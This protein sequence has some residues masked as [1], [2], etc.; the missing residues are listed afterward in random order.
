MIGIFSRGS[1]HHACGDG[2]PASET[3]KKEN[4]VINEKTANFLE[5]HEVDV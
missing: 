2:A 5:Q 3:G 1:N 4:E